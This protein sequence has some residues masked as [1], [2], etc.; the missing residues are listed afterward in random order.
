MKVSYVHIETLKSYKILSYVF[1]KES[2]AE[3]EERKESS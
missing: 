1:Q 3:L 2:V